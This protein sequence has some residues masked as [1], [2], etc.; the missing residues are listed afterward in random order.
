MKCAIEFCR[1]ESEQIHHT[2]RFSI[3]RSHNPY[4]LAPLCKAHHQI[5]HAGDIKVVEARMRVKSS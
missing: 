2:A 4:F 3:S 1:N 5:A